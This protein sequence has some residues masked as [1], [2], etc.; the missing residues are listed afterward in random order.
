M[1]AIQDDSNQGS[2]DEQQSYELSNLAFIAIE[3][4]L[5]DELDEVNDLPSY[6]QLFEAFKELHNDLKKIRLKNTSLKKKIFGFLNEN[7][8]LQKQNDFLDEKIKYLQVENKMLYDKIISFKEKQNTLFEHEKSFINYLTK[9]NE[10]IKKKSNDL[11][12]I[13][14]KKTDNR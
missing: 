8:N 14:Y 6:D 9:E 10:A 1:V 12:D 2:T 13:H 5:F 11:N 3:D 4:E 7:D